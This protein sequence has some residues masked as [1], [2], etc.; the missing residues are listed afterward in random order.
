MPRQAGERRYRHELIAHRPQPVDDHRQRR[1]RLG[2]V[3][4]GVVEQDDV[5]AAI[6]IRILVAMIGPAGHALD[7]R[8]DDLLDAGP[9]PVAGIDVQP[10]RDIAALLGEQR[11]LDLVGGRGLR[12]AEIG[13]AEEAQRVA[14]ERLEQPL[15]RVEFEPHL[16]RRDGG[17]IG[18]GIG[19]AADLMPLGDHALEQRAF[20]Q[21]ILADDEEGRRGMFLL[22][23]VEDLRRPGAVGTI[24][25]GQRELVLAI[26]GAVDL[27]GLG[28]AVE[29][30]VGDRAPRPCHCAARA[31]HRRGGDLEDL[32]RALDVDVVAGGDRVDRRGRRQRAVI[33]AE[34]RP[35][36]RILRPQPPQRDAADP[37][38]M[39][40]GNLVIGGGRVEQPDDVAAVTLA[41]GEAAVAAGAV[42]GRH[43]PRIARRLP[44][45]LDAERIAAAIV[46]VIGVG[47]DRDDELGG[48]DAAG[49]IGDRLGEPMLRG[50]R[51]GGAA[52][53]MLVIGHQ[54]DLVGDLGIGGQVPIG[55]G[56]RRGDRHAPAARREAAL[57][58]AQERAVIGLR[59]KRQILEI[60]EGAAGGIARQPRDQPVEEGGAR[61][62]IGEQRGGARPVPSAVARV[63][64]HRDQHRAACR[65]VEDGAAGGIAEDGEMMI[66]TGDRD[67]AGNDPVELFDVPFE[68][69]GARRV[70]RRME[71]DGEIGIGRRVLAAAGADQLT[72][73]I[74]DPALGPADHAMRRR[75]A[76]QH[77]ALDIHGQQ[78]RYRHRPDRHR[79][80]R[81]R[82]H[83]ECDERDDAERE[84]PFAPPAG[85]VEHGM[86]RHGRSRLRE[87][88][89]ASWRMACGRQAGDK[90]VIRRGR[91]ACT[92]PLQAR[93][94]CRRV[95]HAPM[96]EAPADAREAAQ[97]SEA[98]SGRIRVAGVARSR[99]QKRRAARRNPKVA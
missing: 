67:P 96:P 53:L 90:T 29:V 89:C 95:G 41:I 87:N 98:R 45:F 48:G 3:A 68:A 4:T 62:W 84:A 54:E 82:Q 57:R 22:E 16:P 71:G 11:R 21:R 14:G 91:P 61:T 46:P 6:R 86:L 27:I 70:P 38:A 65:A 10:D 83:D 25:E 99:R 85:V 17:E 94:A 5:A 59:G 31:G 63:L 30:D 72:G 58:L 44:R 88:C 55:I 37:G 78:R 51:A 75:E 81:D 24:V 32:A 49:G 92:M 7:R 33:A 93:G 77:R 47:A 19:M 80:H 26:A 23:H 56:D 35:Q 12:V 66:G 15:R 42:E 97:N 28:Q 69:G 79:E 43:R 74:F 39:E 76:A 50:D 52:R 64:D 40:H 1:D 20:G 18:V 9:F 2:T 8:V 60:E 36:A 34:Q 73:I 13:R